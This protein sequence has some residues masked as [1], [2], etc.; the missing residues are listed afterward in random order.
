MKNLI[1]LF[2]FTKEKFTG[3]DVGYDES[4]TAPLPN[5]DVKGK[6]E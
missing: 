6:T 1:V 3:A 4:G 2:G 5:D